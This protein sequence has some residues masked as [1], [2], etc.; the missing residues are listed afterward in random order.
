MVQDLYYNNGRPI[1]SRI[2]VYRTTPFST[3]LND[4]KSRFQ[5]HVTRDEIQT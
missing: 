2:M 4:P 1:K 5:V 3:T